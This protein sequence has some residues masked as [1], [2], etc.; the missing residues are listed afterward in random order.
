M[1]IPTH[2]KTSNVKTRSV[3]KM[4]PSPVIGLLRSAVTA[5]GESGCLCSACRRID[6]V[7]HRPCLRDSVRKAVV[8]RR[9]DFGYPRRCG[10]LS[11]SVF[12][13][14]CSPARRD[15]RSIAAEPSHSCRGL[16]CT[17]CHRRIRCNPQKAPGTSSP[18]SSVNKKEQRSLYGTKPSGSLFFVV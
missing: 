3:P 11:A 5:L 10:V 12:P 14:L 2:K 16:S 1:P 9:S 15:V 4:P 7:S 6:S 13:R 8:P 17:V 18:P